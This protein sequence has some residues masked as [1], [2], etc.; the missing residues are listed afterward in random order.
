MRI[1]PTTIAI[2]A[3]AV[4]LALNLVATTSPAANA[5]AN[6]TGPPVPTIVKLL[7]FSSAGYYRVWSDGRVDQFTRGGN[8]PNCDFVFQLVSCF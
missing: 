7:P 3:C 4:L 1:T 8:P 6:A 5:T 2:S